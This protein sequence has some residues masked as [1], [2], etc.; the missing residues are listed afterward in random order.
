VAWKR[1]AGLFF[2]APHPSLKEIEEPNVPPIYSLLAC[3]LLFACLTTT[4]VGPFIPCATNQIHH[5]DI[6]KPVALH[7]WFPVSLPQ[8]LL[9]FLLPG[10]KCATHLFSS[11]LHSIICMFDHCLCGT[12]HSWYQECNVTHTYAL[13][14]CSLSFVF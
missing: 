7:Y 3:P 11:L 13:L 4:S 14:S 1:V 2:S 8:W 5:S 6:L 10:T 9:S 12:F